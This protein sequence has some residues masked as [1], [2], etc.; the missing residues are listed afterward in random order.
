MFEKFY[1]IFVTLLKNIKLKC[2]KCLTL[3]KV[4][5]ILSK[6]DFIQGIKSKR[7]LEFFFF[8][9]GNLFQSILIIFFYLIKKMSLLIHFQ[10]HQYQSFINFFYFPQIQIFSQICFPYKI[11][12]CK[13]IYVS[14]WK[15]ISFLTWTNLTIS[16]FCFQTTNIKQKWNWY[17]FYIN[18]YKCEKKT[19]TLHFLFTIKK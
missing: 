18:S 17:I 10:S 14:I 12:N 8:E 15:T 16:L 11:N 7:I 1:D 5:K 2:Q 6:I 13:K 4:L 3:F 19:H 9:E